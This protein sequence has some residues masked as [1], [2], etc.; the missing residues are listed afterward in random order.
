MKKLLIL[1]TVS[2]FLTTGCLVTAPPG[3]V[4]QATGYNPASGK[5]QVK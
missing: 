5:I 2:A 3:Q 1:M 4:K